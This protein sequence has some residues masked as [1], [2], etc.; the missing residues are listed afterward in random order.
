MASGLGTLT[1][2]LTANNDGLKKGFRDSEK[3]LMDWKTKAIAGSAV[4][5]AGISAFAYSAVNAFMEAEDAGQAL[6]SAIENSGES[7]MRSLPHLQALANSIM[8]VTKYDHEAIESAMAYG[9]NLGIQT[10]QLDAAANAAVGLAAKYRLDLQQAMQLI[11]MASQG[12]TS[13]LKRYGITLDESLSTQEKFNQLLQIGASSFG[14]AEKAA[15]T[16]SGRI[17]QAKNAYGELKEEFGGAIISALNLT[18]NFKKLTGG[19]NAMTNE[20]GGAKGPWMDFA[21]WIGAA[22]VAITGFAAAAKGASFLGVTGMVAGISTAFTG[23]LTTIGLTTMATNGLGGALIYA[24]GGGAAAVGGIIAGVAALGVALGAVIG[25]LE[26]VKN[27]LADTELV[28]WMGGVNAAQD[29]AGKQDAENHKKISELQKQ[30]QA[31]ALEEAKKA[32]EDAVPFVYSGVPADSGKYMGYDKLMEDAEKEK[33]KNKLSFEEKRKDM[34]FNAMTVEEKI[35]DLYRQRVEMT[36]SM[37][38]Y[39]IA[40]KYQKMSELADIEKQRQDLIDGKAKNSMRTESSVVAAV[41]KGSI[42]ALRIENTRTTKDPVADNTL[43]T[44]NGVE[45]MIKAIENLATT[46]NITEYEAAL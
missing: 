10:S 8:N 46:G 38:G 13:R 4:A 42:E 18:E 40:E 12:N 9:K 23:I 43:R 1:V 15:G 30:K 29:A 3:E 35:T 37:D 5:G 20:I 27:Y 19:I 6:A 34:I 44:A 31:V 21:V 17:Q 45:K 26:S 25:Q 39:G 22:G 36:E 24:F 2:W 41:Q 32:A 14:L 7:S 11:G 16:T 33:E 28:K